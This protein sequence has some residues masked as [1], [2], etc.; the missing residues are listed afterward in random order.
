LSV[1]RAGIGGIG[2]VCGSSSSG[3]VILMFVCDSGHRVC[4]SENEIFL[5]LTPSNH[6]YEPQRKL[7]K[8]IPQAAEYKTLRFAGLFNLPIPLRFAFVIGVSTI[9]L[10]L[11]LPE[12]FFLN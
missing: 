2:G 10:L 3:V 9:N 1:G 11:S 12:S 5:W 6:G 8:Q 4:S 7:W